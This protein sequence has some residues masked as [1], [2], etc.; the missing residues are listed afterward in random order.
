VSRSYKQREAAPVVVVEA[1]GEGFQEFVT[2]V[3]PCGEGNGVVCVEQ[4]VGGEAG[5]RG[6]ALATGDVND[7]LLIGAETSRLECG[8]LAAEGTLA[9]GRFVGGLPARMCLVRGTLLEAAGRVALQSPAPIRHCEIEF[10]ESAENRVDLFVEGTNRFDLALGGPTSRV[11]I[12]GG[13]FFVAGQTTATF[14][15][16]ASVWAPASGSGPLS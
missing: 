10:A 13:S 14:L 9:W 4:R 6:F 5:A 8:Q 1:E 11:T 12:G 2:F 16:D 15:Q 3:V 7:V